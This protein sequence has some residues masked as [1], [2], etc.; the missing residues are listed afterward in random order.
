MN[1]DLSQET[2]YKSSRT[3]EWPIRPASPLQKWNQRKNRLLYKPTCDA[4][5]RLQTR[6]T[7]MSCRPACHERRQRTVA[8]QWLWG[9]RQDFSFALST[10]LYLFHW[11]PPCSVT[12][13]YYTPPI[14][15]NNLRTIGRCY[16]QQIRNKDIFTLCCLPRLRCW[17]S[18]LSIWLRSV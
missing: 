16:I 13:I 6:H 10:S 18:L 4:H 14:Y 7:M 2:N 11:P 12:V 17:T 3:S 15:R 8:S 9:T 5:C 1:F